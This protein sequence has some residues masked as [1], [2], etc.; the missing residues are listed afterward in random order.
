MQDLK[1]TLI[2]P[3]LHWGDAPA[4]LEHFDSLLQQCG[5]TDLVI[6]T[7]MFNTGF[8]TQPE[9]VAEDMNGPSLRWM[10]EKAHEYDMALCGSMIIKEDDNYFNRLF[11]V[12]PG[13]KVSQYD[14]RHLFSMAGEH[15][16]FTAGSNR[17]VV[18]FKGWRI[19]PLV[20]Y[21]LRFPVWSRNRWKDGNYD[22]DLLIYVANWPEVRSA[23][24]KALLPAR[25]IENISYVAAVNRVGVDGHGKIHSGDSAV[26]G[27]KGEPLLTFT[28]HQESIT[29]ITLSKQQLEDFRSKFQVGP[30]WD[31]LD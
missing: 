29:S 14:K 4:N 22:Y 13:G 10:K 12:E 31:R 18:E 9:S 8:I 26:I 21:D 28:P 20:C 5:P 23:A 6:L 2:Q 1:I 25:A 24:W 11:F 19:M 30:D 15:H 27:P 3:F 17:L 7:E 16:R